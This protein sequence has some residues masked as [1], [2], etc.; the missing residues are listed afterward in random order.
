[1]PIFYSVGLFSYLTIICVI[2]TISY[3]KKIV[4]NGSRE[5]CV[6]KIQTCACKDSFSFGQL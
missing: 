2:T 6:N 4:A 1:M 5:P 3:V